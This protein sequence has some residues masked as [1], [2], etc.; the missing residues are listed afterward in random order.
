MNGSDFVTVLPFAFLVGWGCV[1]LV[2]DVFYFETRTYI[3]ARLAALGL[4][5]TL[6][7][8]LVTHTG[9]EMQ[10]YNHMISVDGFAVFLTVL[11]LASGLVA[12]AISYDYLT[13]MGINRGEYYTLLLFS[14]SGMILMAYASD[15]IVVF[16]ALELLSIP[17]YV[18]AGMARPRVASEEAGGRRLHRSTLQRRGRERGGE[19]RERRP[20]S[21]GLPRVPTE[22]DALSVWGPSPRRS[23]VCL[24]WGIRGSRL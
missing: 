14:I 20:G 7:A 9:R 13:R 22:V 21:V 19:D 24:P 23:G 2:V 6:I 4:V 16:L 15:L 10:A 11:F 5:L 17:L 12:I 3:T 18:M 8:T 1:L